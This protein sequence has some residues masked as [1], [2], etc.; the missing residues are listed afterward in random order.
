[1]KKF[2]FF[3]RLRKTFFVCAF[4]VSVFF[5]KVQAIKIIPEIQ[6]PFMDPGMQGARFQQRFCLDN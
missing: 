3:S 1:M 2:W 4:F 5:G 6:T